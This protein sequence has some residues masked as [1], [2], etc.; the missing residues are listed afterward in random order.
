M[1]S[2]TGHL[3]V[4]VLIDPLDT[5]GDSTSLEATFEYRPIFGEDTNSRSA[6]W[7]ATPTQTLTK[8][9]QFTA[10]IENLD[11]KAGYEY[12]AVLHHPL[13]PIYGQEQPLK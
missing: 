4:Q 12:R 2:K 3:P 1:A 8:P 9:G 11:P 6:P 10:Q 13:L 5:I 7:T